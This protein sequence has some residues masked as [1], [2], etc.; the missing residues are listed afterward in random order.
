MTGRLS[1]LRILCD[2]F[3]ALMQQWVLGQKQSKGSGLH[4][5]YSVQFWECPIVCEQGTQSCRILSKDTGWRHEIHTDTEAPSLLLTA[6]LIKRLYSYLRN[7]QMMLR[8][9]SNDNLV[10]ISTDTNYKHQ[11]GKIF[12]SL[13]TSM[14]FRAFVSERPM[15]NSMER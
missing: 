15:R 13:V 2:D 12:T 4:L 5:D 6:G 7:R 1:R 8:M 3:W 10:D 14:L 9:A 11:T